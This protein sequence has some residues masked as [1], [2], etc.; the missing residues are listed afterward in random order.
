MKYPLI[1]G[2]ALLMLTSSMSAQ[3]DH[4]ALQR[5]DAQREARL[6]R[7]RVAFFSEQL[8][9]TTEEAQAFWP[10]MNAHEAA[11]ET[12]REQ[13]RS[14]TETAPATE[15]EAQKLVEAMTKLRKQEVDVD[16]ALL[17]ELIPVL[18]PERAMRLP[19]L[20]R[21]FRMRIMEAAQG[22]NDGQ[23]PGAPRPLQR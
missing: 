21:K 22:R 15:S 6:D 3:P 4:H 19:Q 11:L 8:E 2:L 9:L 1:P 12:L 5:D 20:E 7:L 16:G 10:I 13:M 14:L 23:R 18:G 17:L